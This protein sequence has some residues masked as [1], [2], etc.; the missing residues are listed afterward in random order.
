MTLDTIWP[1]SERLQR[2]PYATLPIYIGL[3]VLILFVTLRFIV[4]VVA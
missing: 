2:G 4:V 3:L 1:H